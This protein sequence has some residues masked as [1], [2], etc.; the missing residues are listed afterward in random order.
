M[1]RIL[2]ER[3]GS[4]DPLAAIQK[5]PELRRFRYWTSYDEMT[6]SKKRP[7]DDSV[8]L[9]DLALPAW[10]RLDRIRQRETIGALFN[11]MTKEEHLSVAAVVGFGRIGNHIELLGRQAKS[12]I[13]ENDLRV[14]F[15]VE[16]ADIEIFDGTMLTRNRDDLR[17]L[18][19]QQLINRPGATLEAAL[20]SRVHPKRRGTILILDWGKVVLGPE[21]TVAA[22][23]RFL[24]EWCVLHREDVLRRRPSVLKVLSILGVELTEI[25]YRELTTGF[26]DDVQFRHLTTG[27]EV[28]P[29]EELKD[30][31]LPHILICIQQQGCPD[32][33]YR[34]RVA[35]AVFAAY[36]GRFAETARA[37]DDLRRLGW[38]EDE[39]SR[40][41]DVARRAKESGA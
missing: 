3:G 17:R 18:L 39:V 23:E 26:I 8:R 34:R 5:E 7:T 25:Q 19:E 9:P 28:A 30:V 38:H 13:N 40:L 2:D 20:E 24:E 4:V 36:R 31:S 37:I 6:G 16:D 14:P 10:L 21:A 33:D 27:F 22:F 15:G 35:K 1:S 11:R 12:Y 32:D 41:E 29:L